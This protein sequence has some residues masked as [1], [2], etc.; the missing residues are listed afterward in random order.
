MVAAGHVREAEQHR[1][2]HVHERAHSA[3]RVD[4]NHQVVCLLQGPHL[5]LDEGALGAKKIADL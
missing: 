3:D 2:D 4:G 5:H 1:A